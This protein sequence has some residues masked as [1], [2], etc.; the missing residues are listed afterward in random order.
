MSKKLGRPPSGNAKRLAYV[1]LL[2]EHH[3]WFMNLPAKD[4]TAWLATQIEQ[5]QRID[6]QIDSQTTK[7]DES[8]DRGSAQ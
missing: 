4:R 1:F 3:A 7:T 2:P 6:S 5:A 8:T